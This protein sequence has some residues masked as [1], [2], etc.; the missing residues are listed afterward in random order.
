MAQSAI[1]FLIRGTFFC[2]MINLSAQYCSYLIHTST[3]KIVI[4]EIT[5]SVSANI[6][7][8]ILIMP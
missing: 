1:Q 5:L 3:F 2:N 8:A 4:I 6:F 7:P